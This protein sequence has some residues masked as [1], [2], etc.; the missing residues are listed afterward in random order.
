M[1]CL[2]VILCVIFPPLAVLDQGCGS[3]VIVSLLTLFGWVPGVLAALIIC[4]QCSQN[5]STP[6]IRRKKR[7]KSLGCVSVGIFLILLTGVI[8]R[9]SHP[10]WYQDDFLKPSVISKP[11]VKKEELVKKPKN[12]PVS[13]KLASPASIISHKSIL[14]IEPKKKLTPDEILME[15]IKS[16]RLESEKKPGYIGVRS[17][18][19]ENDDSKGKRLANGDYKIYVGP[20]GGIYHYSANGNKVYHKKN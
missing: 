16:E 15:K 7:D 13:P 12:I 6:I 17:D 5:N 18:E 3:L 10:E 19:P 1:G 2:R 20:R 11:L 4:S 9:C 8:G 14:P